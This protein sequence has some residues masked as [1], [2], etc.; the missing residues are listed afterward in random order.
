MYID[1]ALWSSKIS[2]ITEIIIAFIIKWNEFDESTIK[3][4]ARSAEK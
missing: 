1:A 2:D 4:H 3:F